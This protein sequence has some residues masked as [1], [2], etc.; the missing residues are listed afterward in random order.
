MEVCVEK[1]VSKALVGIEP[2]NCWETVNESVNRYTSEPTIPMLKERKVTET[3]SP[4][5]GR[6]RRGLAAGRGGGTS[7][8]PGFRVPSH[9]TG[10]FALCLA[11][12]LSKPSILTETSSIV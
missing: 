10:M 3:Y 7:S 5:A 4:S 9:L 12:M 8:W 1:G 2:T 6:A 11:G